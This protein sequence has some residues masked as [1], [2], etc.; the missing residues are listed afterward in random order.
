MLAFE[1][2]SG[3]VH[4]SLPRCRP[5]PIAAGEQPQPRLLACNKQESWGQ[6]PISP[7]NE[8]VPLPKTPLILSRLLLDGVDDQDIDRSFAMA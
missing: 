3:F 4:D 8:S 5:F 6:T 2:D 7:T 1:Q